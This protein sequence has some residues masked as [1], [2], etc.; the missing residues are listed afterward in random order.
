MLYVPIDINYSPG[1]NGTAIESPRSSSQRNISSCDISLLTYIFSLNV[2]NFAK[3]YNKVG[4][5]EK[6]DRSISSGAE[7]RSSAT[8]P[9]TQPI[10]KEQG[11][12]KK[13]HEVPQDAAVS[14]GHTRCVSRYKK[15]LEILVFV[16]DMQHPSAADVRDDQVPTDECI[17]EITFGT[18]WGSDSPLRT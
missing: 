17:P 14:R 9:A 1:I 8:C 6:N 4:N 12:F 15:Y 13:L 5:N 18:S 16:P 3:V 7:R 10:A 11:I 2:N